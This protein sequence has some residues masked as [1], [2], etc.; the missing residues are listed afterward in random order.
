MIDEKGKQRDG[1]H[2]KRS[3]STA[4]TF[5]SIRG[6]LAHILVHLQTMKSVEADQLWR[7]LAVRDVRQAI[8]WLDEAMLSH[9]EE[10]TG[11]R[12]R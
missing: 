12:P 5:S 8:R 3:A 7:K 2:I 6:D 11:N 4:P 1:I 10:S 9:E